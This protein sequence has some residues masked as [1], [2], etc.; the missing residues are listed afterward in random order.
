MEEILKFF[1][2]NQK[3]LDEALSIYF[4]VADNRERQ[5]KIVSN[6]PVTPFGISCIYPQIP[7]IPPYH[8]DAVWPFV[9]SYWALASAKA[10]N[11]QSVVRA[12]CSVYRPAA[13]FLTNKENFVASDGDYAGTQINSSN[14][15]WSLSGNLS[16]VYR[17]LFG[18]HF[19]T[20]NLSFSPYV[21]KVFGGKR[22]LNNFKY[23]NAVLNIELN[24]FGDIITYFSIDGKETSNYLVPSNLTGTHDI[25]IVLGNLDLPIEQVNNVKDVFSPQMPTVN[26]NN[27]K[28][29]WQD[30]SKNIVS[31]KVIKNG[32]QVQNN[33]DTSF[34]TTPAGYGDYQ[35][36][37]VA[38]NKTESFASE[39]LQVYPKANEHIIQLEN[40]VHKSSKPYKG[41]S[42]NG[43]IEIS[44]TVNTNVDF[45]MNVKE[46]GTYILDV[47]YANGNGPINT[48]NKCAFRTIS[49]DSTTTGT[50]VFP[51]RGKDEWS[52]WG[53]SNP[54]KLQ[55]KK[56][57]HHISI[58]FK[59]WNE[60]MN[61]AINQAMLDYVRLIKI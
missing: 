12:M 56:G 26:Y 37:A 35:V 31:F 43:F 61:G 20:D 15:L 32:K 25:K 60:N 13:L 44:K 59:P 38:G 24:G 14:M 11:E 27:G 7:G 55:L 54:L 10:G 18:I 8:N 47:R 40:F 57:L 16:L 17:I 49:I 51:Q 2:R 46:D 9:E 5:K 22:T 28:L 34:A 58:S 45:T 4:D 52:N 3:R 19:N 23:R 6:T 50:L 53:F 41:F 29:S 39:P 21:P 42:G 30:T 48:E 1:L 33:S 36:I